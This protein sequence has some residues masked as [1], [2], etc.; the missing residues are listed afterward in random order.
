MLNFFVKVEN[1]IILFNPKNIIHNIN[2]K[3]VL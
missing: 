2:E 3:Y 1:T